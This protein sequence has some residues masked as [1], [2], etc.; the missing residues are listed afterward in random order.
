[1]RSRCVVAGLEAV[2]DSSQ[3]RFVHGVDPSDAS[4]LLHGLGKDSLAHAVAAARW[5][6][7]ATGQI[8]GDTR[9][10]RWVNTCLYKGFLSICR[11]EMGWSLC[12]LLGH[13][14]RILHHTS[15]D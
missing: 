1:M 8:T 5:A 2:L 10:G 9:V 3:L 6:D 13:R 11:V 7:V 4:T 14:A 15:Y 12:S